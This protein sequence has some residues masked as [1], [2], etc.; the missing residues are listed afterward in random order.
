MERYLITVGIN[1]AF[2]IIIIVVICAIIGL[3]IGLY[4]LWKDS[5]TIWVNLAVLIPSIVNAIIIVI[6]NVIFSTMAYHLTNYE[7]HAT[8][9]SYEKALIIKTFTF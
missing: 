3:R 7:N 8:Q 1:L 6:L 5:G 2:F 9:S 4:E